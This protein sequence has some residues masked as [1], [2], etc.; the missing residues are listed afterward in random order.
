[1]AT[2][3]WAVSF[4]KNFLRN[5]S[6]SFPPKS[7]SKFCRTKQSCEQLKNDPK[8]KKFFINRNKY[9]TSKKERFVQ[10]FRKLKKPD[11]LDDHLAFYKFLKKNKAYL[12]ALIAALK[13]EIFLPAVFLCIMPF[14][15]PR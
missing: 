12:I 2:L 5:G 10:T 14:A 8:Q 9:R 13:R 7:Y 11:S 1:M 3:I 4:Q 15:T 6:R